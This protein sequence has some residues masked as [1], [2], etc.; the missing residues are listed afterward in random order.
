MWLHCL[1]IQIDYGQ[2]TNRYT[3]IDYLIMN[4]KIQS[5]FKYAEWCCWDFQIKSENVANFWFYGRFIIFPFLFFFA[6][7]I[8]LVDNAH[9]LEQHNQSYRKQ[10]EK[11]SVLILAASIA[12]STDNLKWQLQVK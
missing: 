3:P 1:R 2:L 7:V 9:Y 5:N 12:S 11:K 4:L 6:V 8:I 10:N